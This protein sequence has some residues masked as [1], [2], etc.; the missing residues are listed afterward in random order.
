[1]KRKHRRLMILAG[2][3]A[4]LGVATFLVVTA[5]KDSLVFFMSPTEIMAAPPPPDRPIRVGGL[6][7]EGSVVRSADDAIV[8][9]RITD[10]ATTVPVV[11][12]GVL[13]DLFSEGQGVVVEGWLDAG[14]LVTA[15]EVLAKHDENYMPPEVADAIRDSGYWQGEAGQGEEESQP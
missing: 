10:L 15:R 2:G 7:E 8:T 3:M 11:Y 6:V 1:M 14:G 4:L 5:L 9:F 13:P 12:E